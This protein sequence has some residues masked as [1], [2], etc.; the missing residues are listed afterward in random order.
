MHTFYCTELKLLCK[1]FN[2]NTYLFIKINECNM[3]FIFRQAINLT[4][5]QSF[6]VLFKKY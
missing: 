4:T 1:F 5:N 3:L 2:F 6:E